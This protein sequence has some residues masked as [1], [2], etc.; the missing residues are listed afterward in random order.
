[1][2]DDPSLWQQQFPDL[3]ERLDDTQRHALDQTLASHELE[4]L[5]PDRAFI[6]DHVGFLTG[7]IDE[8][9]YDERSALWAAQTNP[10][11]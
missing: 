8:H 4:G 1:M 10:D 2:S 11:R 3:Y 5:R 9:E 7:E 6:A